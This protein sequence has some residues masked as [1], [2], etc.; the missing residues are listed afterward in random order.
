MLVLTLLFAVHGLMFGSAVVLYVRPD[1]WNRV[2]GWK[3]TVCVGGK[4]Y[5]SIHPEPKSP[6]PIVPHTDV[7]CVTE[8]PCNDST[9]GDL[10][11][12]RLFN[13]FGMARVCYPNHFQRSLR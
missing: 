11:Q 5:I 7:E 8:V 12:W 1:L 13:A 6:N 10:A 2:R 4:E 3:G 9:K